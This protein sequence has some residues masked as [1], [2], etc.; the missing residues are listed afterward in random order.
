MSKQDMPRMHLRRSSDRQ[1][2]HNNNEC[3]KAEFGKFFT[4]EKMFLGLVSEDRNTVLTACSKLLK[5]IKLEPQLSSCEASLYNQARKML[6]DELAVSASDFLSSEVGGSACLSTESKV[7]LLNFLADVGERSVLREVAGRSLDEK[8][9]S[10][11][12]WGLYR[13]RDI[14]GLYA[15][16]ESAALESTRKCAEHAV[17]KFEQKCKHRA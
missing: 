5:H 17:Y 1:H 13:L 11:S 2:A 14:E 8:V 7:I 6:F 4:D 16:V 12:V 15:L 9:A 3:A 10:A